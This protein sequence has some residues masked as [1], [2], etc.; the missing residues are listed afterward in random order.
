MTG[1]R[2]ISD[3]L[4][5]PCNLGKRFTIE[6]MLNSK[7]INSVSHFY[8]Q[9]GISFGW[10]VTVTL[11][12]FSENLPQGLC[13]IRVSFITICEIPRRK[14]L[15]GIKIILAA[16]SAHL[17]RGQVGCPD[18]LIST[19]W[20]SVNDPG[21]EP[22]WSWKVSSLWSLLMLSSMWIPPKRR[23]LT[24]IAQKVGSIR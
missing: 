1:F 4:I 17:L 22:L 5:D 8:W 12:I 15:I 2:L 23:L 13:E 18:V 20:S 21:K 19:L 3:L 6:V 10:F 7:K 9:A 24:K 16:F 14:T 11:K